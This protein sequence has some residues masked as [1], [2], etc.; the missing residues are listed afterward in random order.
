[1]QL[2]KVLKP[3]LFG[4]SVV[5]AGHSIETSASHAKELI[6]LNYAAPVSL[7]D[8]TAEPKQEQATTTVVAGEVTDTETT[9]EKD[10]ADEPAD[11]AADA[12]A[13]PKA[14]A[15]RSSRARKSSGDTAV[16]D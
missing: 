3:F 13:A 10:Q 7:E 12:K 4:G 9:P 5:P 16:G 2:L 14:R 15:G 1:M 8:A 11:N 6:A